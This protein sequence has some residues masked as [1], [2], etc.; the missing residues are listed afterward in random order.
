MVTR[1]SAI[2]GLPENGPG[3]SS[4][5]YP[6]IERHT[7]VD[8]LHITRYEQLPQPESRNPA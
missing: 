3:E 5:G 1:H 4:P 8:L 6:A 2:V 7:V